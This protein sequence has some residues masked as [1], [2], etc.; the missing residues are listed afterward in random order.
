MRRKRS[1]GPDYFEQ[2]YRDNADPWDFE[3]S[4]YEAKKYKRTLDALPAARIGRALEV[5]C[6]NGVLTAHLGL[7]CEDLLAVDV[8]ETALSVARR[9]CAAQSHIRF[10]RR[11]LPEDAPGGPFDL[12]LLSEVAYYWDSADLDRLAEYLLRATVSGGH[13]LLVH[14]TGDTDYPK[15]GDGAVSELLSL[16]GNRIAPLLAERH[17]QYRLDLWRKR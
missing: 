16:L 4:P 11:I 12:I 8:S 2:L 9:R 7:R 6:A 10:E 15:S 13:V 3:T 5:G 17:E 1:I 14:W